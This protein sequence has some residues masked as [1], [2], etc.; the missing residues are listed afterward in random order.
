[1]IESVPIVMFSTF[2]IGSAGDVASQIYLE[3]KNFLEVNLVQSIS[4]GVTNSVLTGWSNAL[5]CLGNKARLNNISSS[6]FA[7]LTNGPI[8]AFGMLANMEL[9][10]KLPNYTI[11]D[12]ITYKNKTKTLIWG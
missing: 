8:F 11:E 4:A 12:L 5:S 7:T 1:M 2:V 3:E 6:I 9:P 10:K